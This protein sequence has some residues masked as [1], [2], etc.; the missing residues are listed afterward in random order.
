MA[1]NFKVKMK[2]TQAL[3]NEHLNDQIILN[4]NIYEAATFNCKILPPGYKLVQEEEIL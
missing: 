2:K 3:R 1:C 4:L